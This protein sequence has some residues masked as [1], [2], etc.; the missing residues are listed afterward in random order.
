MQPCLAFLGSA[1]FHFHILTETIES[2]AGKKCQNPLLAI[3]REEFIQHW[4]AD[5]SRF[6]FFVLCSEHLLLAGL[7]AF[8]PTLQCCLCAIG[9]LPAPECCCPPHYPLCGQYPSPITEPPAFPSFPALKCHRGICPGSDFTSAFI[10]NHTKR[11]S[12]RHG[13]ICS[14]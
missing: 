2:S 8:P 5:S 13:H 9:H 7:P 14:L 3:V 12:A 10:I 4:Q 11:N 1:I 6:W